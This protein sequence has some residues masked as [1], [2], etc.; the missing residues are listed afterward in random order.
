MYERTYV[1][2]ALVHTRH[3][4]ASSPRGLGDACR[5]SAAVYLG[6]EQ[7][8]TPNSLSQLL[9]HLVKKRPE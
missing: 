9:P 4:I 5:S 7:N 1:I 3:R 2:A 8:T 6:D